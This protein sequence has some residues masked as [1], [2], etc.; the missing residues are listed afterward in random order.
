MHG[1]HG[2]AGARLQSTAHDAFE[3]HIFKERRPPR[4]ETRCP[5]GPIR[6]AAQS[7]P[8]ASGLSRQN[9]YAVPA[10]AGPLIPP[11]EKAY[12]LGPVSYEVNG[13]AVVRLNDDIKRSVVFLGDVC[14][15]DDGADDIS[16]KG[17]GFFVH[18]DGQSYLITAK[19]IAEKLDLL[20]PWGIRFNENGG[21]YRIVEIEQAA[22]HVHQDADIAV[23]EF[24]PPNW[25]DAGHL[26]PRYFATEAKMKSKDIGIGDLVYVVGLFKKLYGNLRSFPVMHT[27][28]IA[29]IPEGEKVPVRD[30][31]T[32]ERKF[33]E[34][35]LVEAKALPGASG[36]PAIVRCSIEILVPDPE[37]P[38]LGL[39]AWVYGS[40]WLLGVWQASWDGAPSELDVI[41]R[42]EG[43]EDKQ[44]PYGMGLVVP[45]PKITEVLEM[46]VLKERRALA[47]AAR[48][49]DSAAGLDFAG[50]GKSA[51]RSKQSSP[52][53]R[54][55]VA[56]RHVRAG[57][58]SSDANNPR[59]K[60]DFTN[61]LRAAAKGRKRDSRT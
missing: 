7:G 32:G 17:T 39:R 53:K 34:A 4:C 9:K 40:A 44:V 14:T 58:D 36:A 35:Y 20:K 10:L 25:S 12:G 30:R 23:L 29:L 48:H 19:H 54:T 15:R 1:A 31:V 21:N 43:R 41:E 5:R 46:G 50:G 11:R 8:C 33:V 38:K 18:W 52:P 42:F 2:A 57:D 49:D 24:S 51:K 16:P 28:H 22:W 55:G 26:P 13:G 60:E 61:L 3:M 27:G 37:N 47:K 56:A 45:A 59:H 6:A